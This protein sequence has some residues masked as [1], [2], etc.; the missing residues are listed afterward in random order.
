MIPIALPSI[1][2][3][4]IELLSL[5]VLPVTYCMMKEWLWRLGVRKGH[6]VTE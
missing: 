6:F 3:L 1:G 4:T 5:F 2:G